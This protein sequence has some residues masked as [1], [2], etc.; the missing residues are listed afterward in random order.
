MPATARR[1][2]E[3]ATV[4]IGRVDREAGVIHDVRII[5]SRSLNNRTYTHDALRGAVGKYENVHVNV[6]HPKSSEMA[7]DRRFDDWAGV[8]RNVSYRDGALYGDLHLRRESKWFAQVIEAATEFPK[9]FGLSHV[10]DGDSRY[11]GGREIVEAID[12]VDSVDIVLKPATNAG[13]FEAHDMALGEFYDETEV[14]LT[15]CGDKI[16][17]LVGQMAELAASNPGIVD[18]GLLGTCIE[19]AGIAQGVQMMHKKEITRS[20]GGES[21]RRSFASCRSEAAGVVAARVESSR[22]EAEQKASEV[23]ADDIRRAFGN[24]K[25]SDGD[26]QRFANRLR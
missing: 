11:D 15:N 10:A 26:L 2:T 18:E 9:S 13:L 16:S 1:F 24:Q 6:N 4:P 21:H 14:N 5:G 20:L 8:L 23:L 19:V 17:E 7:E 22:R 25:S 3:R 12:R